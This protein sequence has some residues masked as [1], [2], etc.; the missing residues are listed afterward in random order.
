MKKN[1][2]RNLLMAVLVVSIVVGS[3]IA[4]SRVCE[5]QKVTFYEPTDEE[6]QWA[7]LMAFAK[8][9]LED[10]LVQTMGTDVAI[11]LAKTQ[12]KSLVDVFK[13]SDL[14]S[15]Y[16]HDGVPCICVIGG[17]EPIW[18]PITE[19]MLDKKLKKAVDKAFKQD[20]TDG[21]VDFYNIY[22]EKERTKPEEFTQVGDC[23]FFK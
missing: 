6:R 10:P 1:F 8:T 3:A 2:V 16:I 11:N 5:D 12:G 14:Y 22:M 21:A 9:R 13:T 23:I 19:D 15:W 18:V 7:Y 20:Y 17:P 4:V